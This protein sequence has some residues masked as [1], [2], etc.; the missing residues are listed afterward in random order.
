[1]L[2]SGCI[3]FAITCARD[4]WFT[5]VFFVFW[6]TVVINYGYLCFYNSFGSNFIIRKMLFISYSNKKP[7]PFKL[8][9]TLINPQSPTQ[10]RKVAQIGRRVARFCFQKSD[11]I[12]NKNNLFF[13]N[14]AIP[15]F[16]II[17]CVRFPHMFIYIFFSASLL[18]SLACLWITRR[19]TAKSSTE[20][21][22][23]MLLCIIFQLFSPI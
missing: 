13:T 21:G 2:F 7:L 23:S 17:S 16:H 10:Y 19:M 20:V 14:L 5:P 8:T 15:F 12:Y 18:T 3:K 11:L 4:T 6:L 9:K 1:M 22:F